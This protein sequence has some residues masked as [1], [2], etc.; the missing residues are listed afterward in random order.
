MGHIHKALFNGHEGY[1]NTRTG[2]VKFGNKVFPCI[3]VA[4]KYLKNK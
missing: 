3:E 1:Y 2:R 4:V